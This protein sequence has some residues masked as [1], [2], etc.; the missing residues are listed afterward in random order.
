VIV[1]LDEGSVQWMVNRATARERSR[2][3]AF[4]SLASQPRNLEL[5]SGSKDSE[6]S[7]RLLIRTGAEID[8]VSCHT[9]GAFAVE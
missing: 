1:A 9:G 4:V 7:V 5:E 6:Q 2:A 3:V 8:G